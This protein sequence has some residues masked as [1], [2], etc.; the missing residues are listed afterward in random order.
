MSTIGESPEHPLRVAIVGS[1]PAG[2]YAAAQLL[3][4]PRLAVEVDMFDRLATP[5]GLVRAGV[6]PDHPKIKSVTRVYEKTARK[7]GLP[8][9]RQRRDRDATSRHAE[10]A[11]AY[12]AVLYARRR[13]DGPPAR[14]PR[15]GPARRRTPRPTSSPGTT[16][17]PTAADREFDLGARARRGDRQ[18][19][20]RARRRAHAGAHPRRARAHRH[21]RPRDRGARRESRSRRSSC[22]AGAAPRRPPSPTPSCA[23]SPSWRAPT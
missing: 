3:S 18:R 8:L 15:R 7:P 1:G 16:A 9:P 2:F 4:D 5:W 11:G 19:Q 20:R 12:H 23:S 17:T 13:A 22:S 21:R 14:H 6:A 10:L